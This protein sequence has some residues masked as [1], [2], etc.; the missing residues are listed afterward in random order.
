MNTLQII[1]A[2]IEIVKMVEKLIPESGQGP[3]KL[4]L[5]RQLIEQA[6]GDVG[7][8]WPQIETIIGVFVKIANVAGTF[9]TAK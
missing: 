3:N 4:T 8:I 5:V 1:L 2:V 9:K 6:V 7:A